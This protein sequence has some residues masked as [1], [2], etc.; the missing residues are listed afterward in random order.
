MGG[1]A[2]LTGSGLEDPT[3]ERF[4]RHGM[5]QGEHAMTGAPPVPAADT[6]EV[7]IS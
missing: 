4:R 7:T 6:H 5:D 1:T 3:A 2:E